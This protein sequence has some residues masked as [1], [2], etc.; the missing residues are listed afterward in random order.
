MEFYWTYVEYDY[1]QATLALA[2]AR[3]LDP[4]D[5]RVTVRE[6]VVAFIFGRCEQA[7][8][9]FR[10]LLAGDGAT[11]IALIGLMESL[12]RA[13][14]KDEAVAVARQLPVTAELPNVALA[15]S[16]G[17]LAQCGAED[18][19]RKRLQL[20]ESRIRP[21][22]SVP[23]FRAAI[24]VGLGEIDEAFALYD[25][26]VE[27][28]DSALLYLIVLP[29]KAGFQDDPRFGALLRRIGLGHLVAAS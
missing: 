18:E 7:E 2:R 16:G 4:L 26:A 23:F 28:R 13:G 21:G 3:A 9:I 17:L 1:D 15:V 25:E 27:A 5:P 10:E 24:H 29:K 12:H 8:M 14:R 20:L 22:D 6:G 19:A 11:P